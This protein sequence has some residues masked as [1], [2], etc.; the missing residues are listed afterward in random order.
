LI[1]VAGWVTDVIICIDRV[2]LWVCQNLDCVG[3]IYQL[4][5][6]ATC[7]AVDTLFLGP[8]IVLAGSALRIT[9]ASDGV[10]GVAKL[11]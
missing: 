7:W 5:S 11:C 10:N 6:A 4:A 8:T 2:T 1:R 3:S 9:D